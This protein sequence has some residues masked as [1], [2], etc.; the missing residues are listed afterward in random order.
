MQATNVALILAAGNG[1]RLK[2]VSGAL[3]KPLVEVDG[4][5]M[6]EHVILASQVAGIERFVIVLGYGGEG[7]RSHLQHQRF[8][9]AKIEFVENPEYYK[10]NGISAMKARGVI[11]QPF[12]LLMADHL[13]DPQ[14]ASALLQQPI[15]SDTTILAVDYKLDSIFDMDDATKV[16]C[17]GKHITNIGKNL[18][19][20]DAVDTGMFLCTPDLFWALERSVVDG[21]C[22]L[23][24][25]MKYMAARRKLLAFDIGDAVW[26]DVDTPEALAY[27]SGGL[28]ENYRLSPNGTEAAHV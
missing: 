26:Q 7:I 16:A 23:S 27:A 8:P 5:P 24:H 19:R 25:G 12:L 22:S 10:S 6:L 28:L 20:Y 21:D 15:E 13:F 18:I 2:N 11:Q 3:P 17:R 9:G 1:S 14:T 4:R